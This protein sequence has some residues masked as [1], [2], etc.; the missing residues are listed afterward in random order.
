MMTMFNKNLQRP[1]FLFLFPIFFVFH[2][3]TENFY[4]VS[5]KSAL[6]LSCIYTFSSL[7]LT[8]LFYLFSKRLLHAALMA[9]LV[10]A[11]NFFF[12][13]VHDLI[14]EAAGG[15]FLEKYSFLAG[16][17]LVFLFVMFFLL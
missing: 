17:F 2:G 4:F 13:Y 5:V 14:K 6:L 7:L 11:F 3:F 1:F 12:G 9:A 16:F 10:M 8:A 15:T